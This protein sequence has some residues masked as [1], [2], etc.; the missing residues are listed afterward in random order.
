MD[1]DKPYIVFVIQ[2][3]WTRITYLEVSNR[4]ILNDEA[5]CSEVMTR[6]WVAERTLG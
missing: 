1:V 2:D 4:H 6:R 3:Q 5:K